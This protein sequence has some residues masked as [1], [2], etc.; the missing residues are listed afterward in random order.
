ME[1]GSYCYVA[2]MSATIFLEQAGV[3]GGL[4]MAVNLLLI[5]IKSILRVRAPRRDVVLC[6]I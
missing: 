1:K 3:P 4:A 2:G 6:K 5:T